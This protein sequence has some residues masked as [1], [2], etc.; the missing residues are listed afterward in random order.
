MEKV[1]ET[2]Q[3]CPQLSHEIVNRFALV[4]KSPILIVTADDLLTA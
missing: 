4:I 1:V 2:V 3:L